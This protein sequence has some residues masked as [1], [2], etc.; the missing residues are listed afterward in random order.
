MAKACFLHFYKFSGFGVSSAKS[1]FFFF[2]L[3][4]RPPPRSPLFP[5]PTLFR[6][7]MVKEVPPRLFDYV[8]SFG[9]RLSS[10]CFAALLRARGHKDAEAINAYDL[11]FQTDSKF[12]NARPLPDTYDKINAAFKPHA[13]KLVIITGFIGKDKNG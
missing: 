6:S 8:T 1:N 3:M 12:M 4:I 2:F 13:N 10:K 9:E 11:G 7:P 5:S